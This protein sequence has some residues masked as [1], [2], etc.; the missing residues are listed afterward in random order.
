MPLEDLKATL[1]RTFADGL[2]SRDGMVS[3]A[4]LG[5]PAQKSVMLA[6]GI[7]KQPGWPMTGSST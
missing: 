6:A 5:P 2:W 7:L 4:G 3:P 1:D